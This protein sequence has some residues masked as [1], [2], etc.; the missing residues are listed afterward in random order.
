M[1]R[2]WIPKW[3][4]EFHQSAISSGWDFQGDFLEESSQKDE[5]ND[6]TQDIS[7]YI[8]KREKEEIQLGIESFNDCKWIK[9]YFKSQGPIRFE[10]S[11]D[12]NHAYRV[13]G[14]YVSE[15]EFLEKI[16]NSLK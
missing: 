7:I 5:E 15:K 16:F 9:V 1:E 3:V 8:Y 2:E 11:D 6:G 14:T 10:Y 4:S 13:F 12:Q